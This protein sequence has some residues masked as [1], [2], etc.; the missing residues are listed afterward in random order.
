MNQRKKRETIEEKNSTVK[1]LLYE[2]EKNST[3]NLPIDFYNLLMDL[4]FSNY[5]DI[6]NL[7][8]EE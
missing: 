2:K 7:H 1:V 6:E 4:N 5:P 8:N 3:L